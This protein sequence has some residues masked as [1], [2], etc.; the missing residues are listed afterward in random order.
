MTRTIDLNADL[1][2]GYNDE[3]ILPFVSSCNIACGGHTGDWETI[4]QTIRLAKDS[5]VTLGAHPSYP[6]RDGFGR[7]SIEIDRS[8]LLKAL[9]EQLD[10]IKSVADKLDAKIEHIKP[11][12]A[13][14]NDAARSRI[15]AELIIEAS[16][17][18][19]P[20][21]TIVGPPHGALVEAG[22]LR[23]VKSRRE[24]FADRQYLDDGSL[25]PRSSK[26]AVIEDIDGQVEQAIRLAEG[27][28]VTSLDGQLVALSVETI[29]LH[30]DTKGA[31]ASAQ[32]IHQALTKQGF[33]IQ[34][35]A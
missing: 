19:F 10:L 33:V 29:C 3:A 6:D 23:N 30:G 20:Q 21:A 11:H 12:G 31:A 2:E 4:T 28:G 13:L 7:R 24:G 26:G 8:T 9:G 5:S 35:P 17:A 27:Q 25:M 34:A 18:T 15:L 32:A 22:N 16:Q 14:Y 1:G